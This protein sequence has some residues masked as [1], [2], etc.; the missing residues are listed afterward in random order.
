MGLRW[1]KKWEKHQGKK[2]NNEDTSRVD[3]ENRKFF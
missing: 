3:R 1:T 2:Y